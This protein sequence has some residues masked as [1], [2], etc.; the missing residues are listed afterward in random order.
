M[1]GASFVL[2]GMPPE[3]SSQI[4]AKPQTA[5]MPV[6][7]AQVSTRDVPIYL[8]G[9]GTVQASNTVA[10]RSQVDGK[11]A[12]VN[13]VEGQQ[14]KRARHRNRRSAPV[15]CRARSSPGQARRGRAQLVSDQKDLARFQDLVHKGAGKAQQAVDQ[16]QAKVDN[17]KATIEA[18]QRA[19]R[20]P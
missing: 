20:A 13:F 15:H 1:L 14:V 3:Q 5:P 6:T 18:D 4:Q 10:I 2:E 16:Q 7:A 8:D 19:S 11:L 17:L 9:L 12:S